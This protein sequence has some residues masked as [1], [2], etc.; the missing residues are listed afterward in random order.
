VTAGSTTTLILVAEG[1]PGRGGGRSAVVVVRGVLSVMVLSVVD[2][3][4]VVLSVVVRSVVLLTGRGRGLRGIL[5]VVAGGLGRLD[6]RVCGGFGVGGA[7]G[8][9]RP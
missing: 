8:A 2:L 6:L 5:L 3:S 4:V 9:C 1:T 7:R